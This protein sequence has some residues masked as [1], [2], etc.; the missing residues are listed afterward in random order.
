MAKRRKIDDAV[1]GIRSDP[2][3]RLEKG[4][5][6]LLKGAILLSPQRC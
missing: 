2:S 3:D 1:D 4:S 5:A 6:A